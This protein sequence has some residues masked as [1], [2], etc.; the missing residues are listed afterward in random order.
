AVL[1]ESDDPAR[2]VRARLVLLDT[3][4]QALGSAGH[5]I[6]DG[7]ADAGTDPALLGPLRFWSAVRELL[8]GR[9]GSAALEARR[10]AAL[11]AAAHDRATRV[12]ALGLLGTLHGLR[13]HPR[14]AA[15]A[16]ELAVQLTPRQPSASLLRRQALAELDGDRLA[17]AE[18]LTARLLSRAGGGGGIED[19]MATLVAL[20]RVHARAG[21]AMRAREA[22]A[23]CARLLV[24]AGTASP[25]AAYAEALAEAVGGDP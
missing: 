4:G 16:L 8:G 1:H 23:R 13:G 11:A 10:A 19:R 14:L 12:A 21:D 24:D 17:E 22:A 18:A 6:E 7:L 5:L 20:T 25:L 15:S 9:T 2:R 3:V